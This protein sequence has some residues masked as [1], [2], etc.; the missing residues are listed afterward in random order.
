[1]TIAEQIIAHKTEGR[2]TNVEIAEILGCSPDYVRAAWHR[3]TQPE[4][5][6][7]REYHRAYVEANRKKY[8]AYQRGY[9]AA[10]REKVAAR[11]RAHYAANREK[12]LARKRAYRL[13][14]KRDVA[15]H[16][17]QVSP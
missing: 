8:N 14:K 17:A 13:R 15:S 11:L 1:M 10:N 16:S 9:Y 3:R 4:K 12:M 6:R 5:Y 2:L 7:Y